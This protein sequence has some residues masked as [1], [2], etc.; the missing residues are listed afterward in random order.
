MEFSP[1]SQRFFDDSQA[2][3]ARKRRG[4]RDLAFAALYV[5]GIAGLVYLVYALAN[6][7]WFFQSDKIFLTLSAVGLAHLAIKGLHIVRAVLYRKVIFKRLRAKK[8]KALSR[9]KH[10]YVI[11]PTYK[12]KDWITH[13]VFKALSLESAKT[14]AQVSLVVCT[15]DPGDK[16]NIDK[17]LAEYPLAANTTLQIIGQTGKGK[18]NALAESLQHIK[19]TADPATSVVAFMDGDAIWGDDI[20]AKTLPYFESNPRLGGLTTNE[21][22]L[23][24]GSEYY[25]N[26]FDYRLKIRDFYMSSHSFNKKLLCLTGRFSLVLAEVALRDDFIDI[27]ANDRLDHWLW[28][29]IKFLGGDDKSSWFWLYKNGHK[30]GKTEML[31]IPDVIVHTIECI[32]ENGFVRAQKNL[33]RWFTN[34]ARN[35]ARSLQIPPFVRTTPFIWFCILM[36]R[37]SMYTNLFGLITAVCL[38]ITMDPV[39]LVAFLYLNLISSM[40]VTLIFSVNSGKMLY[41]GIYVHLLDQYV[42]TV[43]KLWAFS[44]MAQQKWAHRGGQKMDVK[45]TSFKQI[46]KIAYGKYEF[47]LKIGIIVF[48]VLL[49]NKFINPLYDLAILGSS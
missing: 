32:D 39:F 45:G 49:L 21:A 6:N 46:L 8:P 20:L 11:V 30:V 40:F 16:A 37:L 26:W 44:H 19:G 36:Q 15:N 33:R 4:W 35:N 47:V 31:Y 41:H 1:E 13:L 7:Y 3:L 22:L 5:A 34:T 14:E 17:T 2:I 18:R 29:N 42:G 48:L 24:F 38:S 25:K 28:G 43:I 10:L 27:M 9:I 12:E 23:S